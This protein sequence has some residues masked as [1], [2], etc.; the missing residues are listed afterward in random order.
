MIKT[1]KNKDLKELFETG[2]SSKILQAQHK[3]IKNRLSA[4]DS[5]GT[6]SQL[7]LPGFKTHPLNGFDPTRYALSVNKVWRIT[8]EFSDGDAYNVDLEQ[9]H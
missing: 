1:F 3:R 8:F 7:A 9:Y 5:A 6:L 4:L 2:S